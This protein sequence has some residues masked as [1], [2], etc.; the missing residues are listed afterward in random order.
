MSNQRSYGDAVA[1]SFGLAKPPRLMTQSLKSAQIAVSKL[2]IGPSQLGLSP[3]IP[4]ED[5]FIVA[6]YMTPV[7][8]HE[9]LSNGR[10]FI[11]QGYERHGMR[12]VNLV[13]AFSARVTHTHESLVFY[14]PRRA[15]DGFTDE[16]GQHRVQHLR[17]EPGIIDPVMASLANA[18]FA[19]LHRPHEVSQ[20]FV[21]HL[22]LAA[23]A[24]LVSHYAGF[25]PGRL[26]AKGG[27]SPRQAVRAEAFLAAHFAEDVT[28]G[29]VAQH[30]GLSRAHF[31]RAFRK[32]M[33]LTPHQW[34]LRYR[35]E[36]AKA[37][38]QETASTIESVAIACGFADQ[39]HL[40]RIF[41]QIAGTSPAAWRRQNQRR[42]RA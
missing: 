32:T 17:C 3:R 35:I 24:H 15:L 7:P 22:V 26:I 36:Q 42:L 39:S 31:A 21:D 16:T 37:M 38:M 29:D 34:L 23:C 8:D 9:L 40:T 10:P 13:G 2:D 5:T 6:V 12:I 14:I 25:R 30:C 28:L 11:R 33:G 19:A 41:T 27:L 20:I 18:L 4:P 1:H